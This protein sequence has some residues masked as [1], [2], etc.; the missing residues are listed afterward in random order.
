[1]DASTVDKDIDM[2][3]HDIQSPLEHA[4]YGIKVVQIAMNNLCSGT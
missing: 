1:L 3:S 4:L 2:V